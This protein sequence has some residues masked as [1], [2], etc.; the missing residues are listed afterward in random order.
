MILITG[1]TAGIGEACAEIFAENRQNLLLVGRRKDR[2]NS[3]AERLHLKWGIDA[4]TYPL[5]VSKKA[6]VEAF[7]SE[8]STE[9]RKTTLL[10]N[11]AGLAKGRSSIQE[12]NT[13]EWDVMIDTNIKGLLYMTHAVLPFLIEKR[14]GHI[15][16]LGSV[17]GRW[18]YPQ[19][20]IYAATKRAVGALTESLRLDLMGTGIRV[21]ELSPGMVETEFSLVR[22]GD[23]KKA[24]AVYQGFE[25]L[26][27]R[28]IAEAAFWAYSRPKHVNIQ[29]M[30][31]YPTAQASTTAV[32]RK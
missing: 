23:P 6:S 26:T 27:A 17:A 12:G 25:P 5:D 10:I 30:V 22:F 4:K 19:G 31:I 8:F 21:T 11:N 32:H 24:S 29:E 14:E 13:D 2:L 3:L 16:N 1:A 20:N 9:L 28:D 7:A 18:M 15:I